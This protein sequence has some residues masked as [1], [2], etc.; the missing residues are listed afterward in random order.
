MPVWIK[1]YFVCALCLRIHDELDREILPSG[2]DFV[3]TL[4]SGWA[5]IDHTNI[6]CAAC[7][8]AIEEYAITN[9]IPSEEKE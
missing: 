2:E 7:A 3:V 6:W 8:R 9:F 4:P 5:Q 1:L